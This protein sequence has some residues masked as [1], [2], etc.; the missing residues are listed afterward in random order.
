MAITHYEQNGKTLWSVYL[1]IR[2]KV[3]PMI[4]AQKRIFDLESEKAALAEEK[5]LLRELSEKLSKLEGQGLSWSDVIDRWEVTMRSGASHHAYHPTT[6]MDYVSLLNRYT[7]IWL[8]RPANELNK[9]DGREVLL[10]IEREG[11]SRRMQAKLKQNINV[12]YEWG[13]ENKFIRGATESPVRGLKLT[14]PVVEKSPEIL[15]LQE[16]R[17]LLCEAKRLEHSWFPI[18]AFALLTG[19]RNGELYALLWSD[20]DLENRHLIVSKSYNIRMKAVKSTKAGY[21]R[22]VPISDELYALLLQL[23]Q[24]DPKRQH[25]LPR[26]WQWEKGMQAEVLRKFCLNI[27]IKSVRFHTLRA[28]FSTQ[29]LSHDIA[30]ARVM[31]IC[32]WRDLKTM[33]HYVRLAGIDEKGATEALK[34]LPSDEALM[35]E[36]V[37]ILEFKAKRDDKN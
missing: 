35:G 3:N 5:K 25:V 15:N 20:V 37:N 24:Q 23:K 36:I 18:W 13:I 6:I 22:R 17:K 9:A 8:H 19:M 32:G 29:L 12:I 34:I 16:I 2:S 27:G 10:L 31:K 28:C 33:Q 4:R 21:W 7:E 26:S 11:K 1:N 14:K 30:P